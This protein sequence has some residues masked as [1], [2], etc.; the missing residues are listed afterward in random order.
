MRGKLSLF[1]LVAAIAAA[2]G[3]VWATN[4]GAPKHAPSGE[5]V[6]VSRGSVSVTVGGIGHVTTLS[7]AARL[8]VPPAAASA[9]GGGSSTSTASSPARSGGASQA[10]ADAVF[11]AGC[12]HVTRVPVH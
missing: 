3:V 9:G 10:P 12:G 7:G 2:G 5:L 8:A 11:P 6:P 1:A 4:R